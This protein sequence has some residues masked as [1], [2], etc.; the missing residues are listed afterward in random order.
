MISEL[1][2][3][4]P[5]RTWHSRPDRLR[6]ERERW[7]E[8]TR[9]SPNRKFPSHPHGKEEGGSREEIRGSRSADRKYRL[10]PGRYLR[11]ISCVFAVETEAEKSAGYFP[12]ER[13]HLAALGEN[14]LITRIFAMVYLWTSDAAY[15]YIPR[16]MYIYMQDQGR[17]VGIPGKAASWKPNDRSVSRGDARDVIRRF[18]A[19]RYQAAEGLWL[20]TT[21]RKPAK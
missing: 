9:R 16:P 6:W 14:T 10:E 2:R 8:S 13:T 20:C 17:N 1:Y 7:E 21:V 19:E 12:P 4:V 3:A 18:L 11:R 5:S 15:I